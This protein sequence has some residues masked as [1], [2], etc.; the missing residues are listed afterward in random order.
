MSFDLS[1]H[2]IDNATLRV[3]RYGVPSARVSMVDSGTGLAVGSVVTLN[4]GDVSML[5]VVLEGGDFGN[6]EVWTV[7]AGAGAWS[8]KVA[9]RAYHEAAGV[10]LARAVA[11]LGTEIGEVRINGTLFPPLALADRSLG[12]AWTRPAGLASEALD[13]ATRP[14]GAPAGTPGQWWVGM[15]GITRCGARQA[16]PYTAPPT[17]TI[18]SY[19]PSTR[20]ATIH[21]ADDALAALLPG[22]ALTATGLPDVLTIGSVVVRVTPGSIE[23]EALGEKGSAELFADL[24]ASLA[25]PDRFA[26]LTP[27]VVAEV[28]G[29]GTS[30]NPIA[31]DPRSLPIPGSP[32]LSQIP[33][34]P[35]CTATLAVGAVVLVAWPGA[36]PSSPTIVAYDPG[37]LP[38]ALAFAAST[39]IALNADA[40]SLG[41]AA[42]SGAPAVHDLGGVLTT[43]FAALHAATGVPAPT[44]FTSA[45]VKVVP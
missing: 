37:I 41:G 19:D 6:A 5:G 12:L 26:R 3:P 43:Y 45:K 29:L 15:D 13:A 30:V 38:A 23:V 44:G 1:G 32:L 9:G 17:L 7:V 24:L 20:A 27:M 25:A 40:V 2:P 11:D 21:V 14:A 16:R 8:S 36:D 28:Q 22:C 35:G 39:S 4:L 33:G 10:S 18:D 34:V 42:G 31:G